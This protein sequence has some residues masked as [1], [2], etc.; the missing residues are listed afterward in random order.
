MK[1]VEYRKLKIQG[2]TFIVGTDGS[3]DGLRHYATD[4]GGYMQLSRW[5]DRK[6]RKFNVHRIVAAAWLEPPLFA[7]QTQID[8]IDGNKLNNSMENLRWV[9]PKENTANRTRLRCRRTVAVNTQT[10][11][12]YVAGS[13]KHMARILG[14]GDRTI[15]KYARL[16]KPYKHWLFLMNEALKGEDT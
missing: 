3:I 8:H 11:I 10:G 2:A 7:E 16:N 15:A 5:V 14:I 9:S 13:P 12:S 4:G 1:R 6:L